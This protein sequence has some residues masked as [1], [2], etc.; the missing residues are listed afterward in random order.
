[1][2]G[3]QP[4]ELIGHVLQTAE[5][6]GEP[7]QTEYEIDPRGKRRFGLDVFLLIPDEAPHMRLACQAALFHFTGEL[8]M[9]LIERCGGDVDCRVKWNQF[10]RLLTAIRVQIV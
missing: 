2:P 7:G 5:D 9:L 6:A 3:G 8:Q 4:H 10:Y 1:M